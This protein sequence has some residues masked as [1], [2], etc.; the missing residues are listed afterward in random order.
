M[1]PQIALSG[2]SGPQGNKAAKAGSSKAAEADGK[3]A[4]AAAAAAAAAKDTAAKQ[5][6]GRGRDQDVTMADA[7]LLLELLQASNGNPQQC[8][9]QLCGLTNACNCVCNGTDLAGRVSDLSL[10]NNSRVCIAAAAA[11]TNIFA[12]MMTPPCMLKLSYVTCYTCP[13]PHQ[14]Q[15]CPCHLTAAAGLQEGA[16]QLSTGPAGHPCEAPQRA[17]RRHHATAQ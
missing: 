15:Y 8:S 6:E 1:F 13:E 16:Q 9:F 3:T 14:Q 12:I 4:A 10:S 7:P 17:R 2:G 5:R 11:S